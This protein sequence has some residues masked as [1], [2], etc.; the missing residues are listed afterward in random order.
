MLLFFYLDVDHR[1][2]HVLTHSFPTRRSSDL[3]HLADKAIDAERESERQADPQGIERTREQ[4]RN[5]DP[6][7]NDRQKLQLR[8]PLA[9]EDHA[10]HRSEA[11]RVGK[12]CVSTGK[13]RWSPDH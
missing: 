6:R 10:E 2:L 4:D 5:A 8:Q 1:Y 11:R 13:S 7:D 3:H 9:E 12:E